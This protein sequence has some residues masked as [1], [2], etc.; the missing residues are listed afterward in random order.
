MNNI[1]IMITDG[2]SL[3]NSLKAPTGCTKL[4]V[5]LT[6]VTIGVAYNLPNQIE[7]QIDRTR[8]KTSVI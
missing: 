4:T 2:F 1:M 7:F 8:R 3:W 5:A 6:C